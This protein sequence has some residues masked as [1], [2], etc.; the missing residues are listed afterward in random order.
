MKRILFGAL[1]LVLFAGAG[2]KK[3]KDDANCDLNSTTIVGNYK[4][5][6]A[7]TQSSPSTPEV[8]VLNSFYEAC[9]LDD[10]RSLNANNTFAYQDLGTVCDPSL[11]LTGTW[12]LSGNNLTVVDGGDTS[13]LTI[14]S[15]NCNSFVIT[16]IE[17]GVTLRETYIKQ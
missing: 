16:T 3:D 1:A 4:L 17:A 13:V 2:C 15:F 10:I 8:S 6:A 5:T 11:S 7:T 14:S 9:E 12:S